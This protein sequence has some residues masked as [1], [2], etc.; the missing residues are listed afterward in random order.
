MNPDGDLRYAPLIRLYT[1]A[2]TGTGQ[3]RVVDVQFFESKGWLD[4]VLTAKPS[5]ILLS[6]NRWDHWSPRGNRR[7]S[8]NLHVLVPGPDGIPD[9]VGIAPL[10]VCKTMLN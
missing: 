8:S 4:A 10:R 2:L 3:V 7:W 6:L 1:V 9:R 5:G